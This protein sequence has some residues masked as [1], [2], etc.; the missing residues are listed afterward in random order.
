[1]WRR[2]FLRDLLIISLLLTGSIALGLIVNQHR[3]SSLPLVYSSPEAR[4][5]NAVASIGTKPSSDI[6]FGA[7]VDKKEMRRIS[8]DNSALILDARSKTFFELGHIP[9]ALSLPRD[10]FEKSYQSLQKTLSSNL[11]KTIVVY[12]SDSD[13]PDSK[14]VGEALRKLGYQD[15]RLFRGGWDEWIGANLPTQQGCSCGD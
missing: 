8:T 12:C 15:V 10:D 5:N 13:C 2:N 1:M 9:S 3:K 4:L 14:R 6:T 7:D 11:S